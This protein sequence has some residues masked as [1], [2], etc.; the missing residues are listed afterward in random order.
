MLRGLVDWLRD[1][2][3]VRLGP[4]GGACAFDDG[5]RGLV[6]WLRDTLGAW[7]GV[8]VC[9]GSAGCACAFAVRLRGLGLADWL[10]DPLA[11]GLKDLGFWLLAA[12][13]AAVPGTLV[14]SE[15]DLLNVRTR[16]ASAS[17]EGSMARGLWQRLSS[18]N[19]HF[20][21]A[22]LTSAAVRR[23]IGVLASVLS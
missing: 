2:H 5:L 19:I 20:T 3:A 18:L 10:D 23:C 14:L 11:V 13:A 7:L 22:S 21:K 12:L 9:P 4:A 1:T 16:S 6:E 15:P 17:D 8:L